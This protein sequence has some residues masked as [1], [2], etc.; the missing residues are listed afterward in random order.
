MG[1][2]TLTENDDVLGIDPFRYPSDDPGPYVVNG[3]GGNDGITGGNFNDTLNGG[4]GNDS[5]SGLKGANILRGGNGDDYLQIYNDSGDTVNA[6]NY[7]LLADNV[8]GDAGNDFIHFIL[9][10][11]SVAHR[12]DGGD[13]VDTLAISFENRFET[14]PDGSGRL[15]LYNKVID[16]RALWTGGW[17]RIDTGIVR[18]IEIL[19]SISG[20]AGNDRII[21]GNYIAPNFAGTSRP[22]DLLINGNAG[23]DYISGGA[24]VDQ[25]DGGT[26][27]D[28]IYGNDGDDNLSSGSYFGSFGNDLIFGGNGN[29]IIIGA[30]GNDRLYGDA[31]DDNIQD[32]GGNNVI[33]G[34]M[35]ND[36]LSAQSGNDRIY[37]GEGDDRI[38]GGDGSNA[39]YGD[40]G[41]DSLSGG[42]NVDVLI[43]GT[44]DDFLA[45]FAG[46]D[47]L[48]GGDG[49][50]LL[51]GLNGADTSYGGAGN[52]TLDESVQ[53][54]AANDKLYGEAGNDIL[55]GGGGADRLFGGTG[56]DTLTG[57]ASRDYFTFTTAADGDTITDFTRTEGDKIY[58]SK[59]V[60]TGFA[61]NGVLAADAFY[62]AAGADAAQDASDRIVYNTTTGAL[63]YD[64]DGTA[65]A[66]AE[67]IATLG[68]G[69]APKLA[70][71][72]ILII[73]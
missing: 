22:I 57:G 54:D 51:Q 28:T 1:T 70:Y 53:D 56:A 25:I 52:D 27:S 68:A 9:G 69:S 55:R 64:A 33:S 30:G 44:G 72:D 13:G 5:L 4:E 58:L 23:D 2:Y 14:L 43:G 34:G 39:L 71:V 46:N 42:G 60:F 19:N 8:F 45:G 61:A 6:P 62:A 35:G 18:N 24:T 37:G 40:A 63:W 73:A 11:A 16:L 67:L 66:A 20:G 15:Y 50:D 3:L 32:Q 10:G 49:T 47:R 29:D 36:L 38:T 26:G 59:A 21:I 17:G 48:S 31:G 12:A 7:D 65:G 41:N